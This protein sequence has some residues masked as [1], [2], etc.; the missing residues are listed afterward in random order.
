MYNYTYTTLDNPQ[1]GQ[2]VYGKYTFAYGINDLGQVVGSYDVVTGLGGGTGYYGFVYDS[3]TYSSFGAGYVEGTD[4]FGI[5]NSGSFVGQYNDFSGLSHGFIYINNTLTEINDPLSVSHAYNGTWPGQ[6]STSVKAINDYDEVVGYYYNDSGYYGFLYS[7]GLYTTLNDPLATNGTFANSINDADQIIGYY[8]NASGA[9]G[10]IYIN[11]TYNTVDDPSG[12]NTMLIAIN[13]NGQIIGDSSAG[14][15][16]YS[17]GA[18]TQIDGIP[19]TIAGINNAGN[20]VG[21]YQDGLGFHGFLATPVA[22]PPVS[23]PSLATLGKLAKATYGLSA[24]SN[25]TNAAVDG[26]SVASYGSNQLIESDKY[27]LLV[28]A[29][30]NSN[31]IVLAIRGTDLGDVW[32][33][34]KNILADASWAPEALGLPDQTP[35]SPLAQEVADAAN[36]LLTVRNDFPSATLTF[37]GHSLGG[38]IAQLLGDVS[39]YNTVAFNAPGAGQFEQPLQNFL[40]GNVPRNLLGPAA[41][42]GNGTKGYNLNLR[43]EDDQAS[44]YGKPIGEQYTISTGSNLD[45]WEYALYN[46]SIDTINLDIGAYNITLDNLGSNITQSGHQNET[47]LPLTGF[48]GPVWAT[49]GSANVEQFGVTFG[50]AATLEENSLEGAVIDI[51]EAGQ[52]N[53]IV[54]AIMQKIYH[55]DPSGASTYELVGSVYS[56]NF[57]YF[58][59][60]A[61]PGVASYNVSL[62]VNGAWQPNQ[63]VEP[64]VLIAAPPGDVGIRYS[65]LDN[66]GNPVILPSGFTIGAAF[67]STGT[68]DGTLTET[69]AGSDSTPSP[70]IN[71]VTPNPVEPGQST[72]LGTVAPM[73]AGDTLTLTE[74]TGIGTLSLSVV[75]PDGTQQLIYTAPASVPASMKDTVS[76]T[77]TENGASS[78][79]WAGVQWDA[80]PSIVAQFPAVVEKT[81]VA[82]I[83]T[84]TPGLPGDT[85]TLTKTAGVGELSLGVVQ[86]DGTQQV[87]YT[88]PATV[89]ASAVD[90]VSYTVADQHNDVIASGTANVQLD[91]GPGITLLPFAPGA[92]NKPITI[93]TA[94]LGL[95]AD[96]LSL[97]VTQAPPSGA[98]TLNGT[99]VQFT[100]ASGNLSKPLTF[101]FYLKDELGGVTPTST[102]IVGG[103]FANNVTGNA[104]GNTDI[105]LGSGLNKITLAGSGNVVD[106]GDGANAVSGGVGNNTIILGSGLDSVTLSGGGN[107]ITLGNGLDSV[108]VGGTGNQIKLGSGIYTVHGGT[109]DTVTLAGN[110]GILALYGTNEMVFVSGSDE[111]VDD[112]SKGIDLV[113]SGKPGSVILSDFAKDPTGVIDLRG[114]IGGFTTASAV[115][116]TLQSD[117]HG[118]AL[119]SFGKAGSLDILNVAPGHLTASQFTFV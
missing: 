12:T 105:A 26:Y 95:P 73:V 86:A 85:L 68:F 88:A 74:T 6:F 108:S 52:L 93:A 22:P 100:P 59:L 82:V 101:S 89:S 78:T 5:N 84:V 115:L 77:V 58:L 31:Q 15:F 40:I 11:G 8:E 67:A 109:S 23:P 25:D 57:S 104:A 50:V 61:Y 41:T 37:T 49:V 3:G 33:A 39:G 70:T 9:H 98:L 44:L 42:A 110:N 34:V 27:G 28:A 46:H 48:G 72:I 35:N 81:Q 94:T 54:S 1:A 106:A 10:F 64:G 16:I 107:T 65:A 111:S 56:P 17:N 62:L 4:L 7:D 69:L 21:Y 29:F 90:K 118:G 114:A 38:A 102:V 83:G 63:S 71:G 55:I 80:G 13:N 24:T 113:L 60:P 43:E 14:N 112:L 116:A 92:G 36:F 75:R 30:Q 51:T 19:G 20:I 53:P 117:H 99:S 79:G 119:L 18:F 45:L 76:Y 91:A 66:G 2:F 103:N 47:P 87:I 32:Q 96:T 97:V